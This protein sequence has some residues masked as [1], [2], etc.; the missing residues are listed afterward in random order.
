MPA[1]TVS[2]CK[3]TPKLKETLPPTDSRHRRDRELIEAGKWREVS[4]QRCEVLG[5]NL[6]RSFNTLQNDEAVIQLS[7][8]NSVQDN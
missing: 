3:F 6:N 1:F 5:M 7:G 2:L 4:I 8:L